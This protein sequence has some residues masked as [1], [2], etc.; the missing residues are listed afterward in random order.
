MGYG[1]SIRL[2][3][4][5]READPTSLGVR[6]GQVCIE[7]DI[8]VRVVAAALSVSRLTVYKWFAGAHPPQ[9]I[10]RMN[11]QKYLDGLV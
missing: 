11:V 10:N 6:L 8:P 4:Q 2:V 1:Y 7:K 3:K 9:G 5:N